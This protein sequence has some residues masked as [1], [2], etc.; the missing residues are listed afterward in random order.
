MNY[1]SMTQK[2]FF[3]RVQER[4]S[5]YTDVQFQDVRDWLNRNIQG[6]SGY[7]ILYAEIRNKYHSKFRKSPLE[8]ELGKLWQNRSAFVEST[9]KVLEESRTHDSRYIF[10]KIMNIRNKQRTGYCP[11][12]YELD[13][14][15]KWGDLESIVGALLDEGRADEAYI[16][17]DM[18][19][20]A[21]YENK[22][23]TLPDIRTIKDVPAWLRKILNVSNVEVTTEIARYDYNQGV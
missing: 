14:L 4:Y 1:A 8:D 11:N 13:F 2:V 21:K 16:S 15:S 18:I 23:I 22:K 3:E 17:G 20:N 9:D 10:G 19:K 7:A 12:N 5:A 6:E